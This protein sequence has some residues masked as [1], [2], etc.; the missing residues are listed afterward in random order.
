MKITQSQIRKIIQEEIAKVNEEEHAPTEPIAVSA[1][2]AD[3]EVI[4]T[5][6][7]PRGASKDIILKTLEGQLAHPLVDGFDAESGLDWLKNNIQG[8]PEVMRAFG[9]ETE[10]DKID[11]EQYARLANPDSYR[12]EDDE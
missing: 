4:F 6:T 12:Y 2:D 3:G 10:Q 11:R 9:L 5:M 8:R 1:V 7:W